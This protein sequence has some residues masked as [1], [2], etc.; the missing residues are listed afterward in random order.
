[1]RPSLAELQ[2]HVAAAVMQPLTQRETMRQRN[3]SGISNAETAAQ[4][5]KPNDRLS[6]FERL[7][8]YNRQYW[9]RVFA[10][11]EEDFPG[12]QA[13]LGRRRFQALMR[14]YLE[15]NPSTSF[16]LRNLGRNLEAWTRTNLQFVEPY[17]ALALDMLRLEWAHIESFDMAAVPSLQ[18]EALGEV[19]EAT[20]IGLQPHVMLLALQHDVDNALIAL[21]RDA[22][23]SNSSVNNAASARV[24]RRVRSLSGVQQQELFLAVHRWQDTVYYKRIT[25]EDFQL[26]RAIRGGSTLMESIEAAFAGS[27]LQDEA[28]AAYLQ[29]A[30][31]H[32]MAM[33]WLCPAQEAAC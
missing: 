2:R 12:L 32:W 25:R 15:A 18:P 24:V 30:F 10:S 21:Q 16:S 23:S 27:T 3:A 11:F 6:S 28:R 20:R 14:A 22:G 26:L 4:W 8:I 7:E 5:I 19:D 9:F 33:G 31:Q 13:V 29:S 1:M 17:A